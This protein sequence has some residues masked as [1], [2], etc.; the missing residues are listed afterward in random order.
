MFKHHRFAPQVETGRIGGPNPATRT[1]PAAK[2]A[3]PNAPESFTAVTAQPGTPADAKPKLTENQLAVARQELATGKRDLKAWDASQ[4]G[5]LDDAEL[6]TMLAARDQARAEKAAGGAPEGFQPVA[7]KL[8]QPPYDAAD[9]SIKPQSPQTAAQQTQLKEQFAKLTDAQKDAARKAGYD[10][11][12]LNDGKEGPGTR[13]S[14]NALVAVANQ[15]AQKAADEQNAAGKAAF[16]KAQA[17]RAKAA[18]P[19]EAPPAPP[20]TTIQ[21]VNAVNDKQQAEIDQLKSEK[22]R[23]NTLG[24]VKAWR[25]GGNYEQ[26]GQQ[27]ADFASRHPEMVDEN[28]TKDMGDDQVRGFMKALE[29]RPDRA[30]ILDKLPKATREKMVEALDSGWT[31]GEEYTMMGSLRESIGRTP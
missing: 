21:E 19:A 18:K 14:A 29:G 13:A 8:Q 25:E 5:D 28:F 6:S 9:R 20:P 16:E 24:H 26:A 10:E 27:I 4:D 7:P 30:A 2:P 22:D 17:E 1:A 3:D 23:D 15:A 31:S 11:T 12:K